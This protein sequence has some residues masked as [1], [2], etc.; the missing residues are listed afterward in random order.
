M[1]RLTN[2]LI[3]PGWDSSR[4]TD[5]RIGKSVGQSSLNVNNPV[6]SVKRYI[7]QLYFP[8]GNCS[9]AALLI[10][11][12]SLLSL[13]GCGL[14]THQRLIFDS[15][16]IQVGIIS[17]LSTD[18]N[19]SPPVINLHPAELT[20][21]EI[22]SLIGSLEVSGW[23]GS[24][25]GIFSTPQPRPLF[26]EAE[27]VLLA[28][29]LA[30]AFRQAAPR[31]RVFFSIENPDA[32]YDSDRTSG[33][34]FFRDDYFHVILTDHYAFLKADPGGGEPRDPR[35]TKG[36]KLWVSAPAKAAIVP[37]NMEPHWTA[38]EKV[39]ISFK[40]KEALAAQ[41]EV[42]A[43]TSSTQKQVVVSAAE[44]PSAKTV[45]P[46]PSATDS[47]NDLRLQIR[48]LTSS[49]LELRSRLKEQSDTIKDLKAELE[50]LRNTVEAGN[51]KAERKSGRK[52]TTP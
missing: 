4:G 32:S 31:E 8:H 30:A 34:L 38:F 35:D 33:S 51:P 12:V 48:E 27:I 23:S 44:Q 2:L 52:S 21:R 6:P 11:L 5:N 3:E 24:L 18:Q 19:A 7:S 36:M 43:P 15:S 42:P 39:H 22:R 46:T 29:P 10:G 41:G 1:L 17:D 13:A 50:Q 47:A 26:T 37:N 28:D 16:G 14:T 9:A 45:A 20:P 49:N 25:V 40:P